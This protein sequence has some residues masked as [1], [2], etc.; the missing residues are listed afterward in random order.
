MIVVSFRSPH[1]LLR[2]FSGKKC[3]RESGG[4]VDTRP[5]HMACYSAGNVVSHLSR[6]PFLVDA[7]RIG[8]WQFVCES[9]L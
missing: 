5:S 9:S 2:W 1:H 4:I 8:H 7:V 3:D 6:G